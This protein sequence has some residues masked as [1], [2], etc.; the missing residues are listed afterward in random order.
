VRRVGK[1]LSR[2]LRQIAFIFYVKE[3]SE[4]GRK[5]DANVF[6]LTY[7]DGFS[8]YPDDDASVE[9]R[10]FQVDPLSLTH[11]LEKFIQRQF[12]TDPRIW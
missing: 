8:E 5:L 1:N 7:G 2:E 4:S 10:I 12:G 9:R 6:D 3:L 11:Q